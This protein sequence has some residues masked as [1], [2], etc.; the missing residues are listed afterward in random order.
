MQQIIFLADIQH[1]IEK[2]KPKVVWVS[3]L[4]KTNNYL[5]SLYGIASA[6]NDLGY[7][8]QLR[9]RT[10]TIFEHQHKEYKTEWKRATDFIDEITSKME[11]VGIEVREGVF[12][13]DESDV[14][15]A[16]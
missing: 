7:P 16:A 14:V 4:S 6:Y 11:A 12:R 1:L 13:V 9:V 10:G 5:F 2:E 3:V 8:V 15:T